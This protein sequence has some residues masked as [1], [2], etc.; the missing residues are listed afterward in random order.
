[1]K[2]SL[3]LKTYETMLCAQAH[4]LRTGHTGKLVAMVAI[5]ESEDGGSK[6]KLVTGR[7]EIRNAKFAFRFRCLTSTRGKYALPAHAV[8]PCEGL[9]SQAEEN[10]SSNHRAYEEPLN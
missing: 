5:D 7:G 8:K 6:A 10:N 4:K 2:F 9:H 1:M 3:S